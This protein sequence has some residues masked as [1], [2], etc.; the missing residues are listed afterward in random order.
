MSLQMENSA[1]ISALSWISIRWQGARKPLLVAVVSIGI[2]VLPALADQWKQRS[3]W[4][5]DQE[6]PYRLEIVASKKHWTVEYRG[7]DSNE[8]T[9]SRFA[10][11]KDLLIPAGIP[12]QFRLTSSDFACI[13]SIIERRQRE[14]AVPGLEFF[15]SLPALD[16]GEFRMVSDP[17]CGDP[18]Q[19]ISRNIVVTSH[20]EFQQW[21]SEQPIMTP[22]ASHLRGK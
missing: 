18:H 5:G 17:I 12:V 9:A 21:L 11:G 13:F 8:N 16:S 10:L 15:L 22:I 6:H 7:P 3:Q 4:L 19:E 2:C 1:R 20:Q 14:L